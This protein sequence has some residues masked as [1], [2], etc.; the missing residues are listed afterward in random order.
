MNDVSMPA[1]R[2]AHIPDAAVYDFDVFLD[3]ALLKNPH[4]R[5]RQILREA[6]PVFWTP[7]NM[8]HWVAISHDAVFDVG[9]DPEHFSS[10]IQPREELARAAL[11]GP[12][13]GRYIPQ[14]VPLTTDAPEHGKLRAPLA[15]TFGPRA[16]RARSEDIRNLAASL[17][18]AVA[19]QGCCDFIAT[20]AEP[21]PVL[22]FLNILG[23][24]G[25]RLQE[26]RRLVHAF[27]APGLSDPA[28]FAQRTRMV[29]DACDEVILARKDDPKD[30]L[31]SLLWRSTIDGQ[32]MTIEVLEDYV[33]LL[34]VAGLDTVIN[35]IGFAVRHLAENPELQDRLRA[36]PSLIPEAVEELLRR[37]PFAVPARRVAKDTEFYGWQMKKDERITL[38]Y[39]G[40]GLDPSRWAAPEAFDLDR[41]DKTH[42]TFGVGPHRC[43]GSHLA[44]LE[45]QLLVTELLQR[46]PRFRLDPDRPVRYHA[47]QIIAVDSLPI[48]WD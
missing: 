15:S 20:V 48:R 2:P 25:E 34:F 10:D 22:V 44:R 5:I 13:A 29:A 45:L 27:L 11:G 18:G 14:A 9:R 7:R 28:Q 1:P 21:L 16:I 23:L 26:F 40:S 17:I 8:G 30:D 6:P 46:I 36:D 43:L 33:V 39:P 37:Y 24:P 3:P 19:D 32:P 12:V 4:E 41:E 38:Y 47:G 31:I 35:G 42:I